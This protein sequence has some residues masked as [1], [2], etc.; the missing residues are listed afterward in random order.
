MKCG[1]MGADRLT[2]P[3]TSRL[4]G[5]AL[6]EPA[7]LLNICEARQVWPHQLPLTIGALLPKKLQGD[8]VI[9][10]RPHIAGLWSAAR[11]RH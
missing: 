10:L 2:L 11:E 6:D 4:P 3:D 5:P 8:R 7:A 1:A 9:G